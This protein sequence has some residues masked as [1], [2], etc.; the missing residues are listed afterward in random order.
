MYNLSCWCAIQFNTFASQKV[1]A[2]WSRNNL[3][4]KELDVMFRSI[5]MV[6]KVNRSLLSVRVPSIYHGIKLIPS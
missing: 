2:A 3:P 4:P 5:E 6:Y 1:A